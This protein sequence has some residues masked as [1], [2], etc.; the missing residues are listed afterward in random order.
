MLNNIYYVYG[1]IRRDGTPYYI[2]KGKGNR[3]WDDHGYHKPPKDR[4]ILIESNLTELGALAI[5]RRLI[6]WYGRKDINTGILMNKT[7]GGDGA[8]NPNKDK[9]S[10]SR[11]SSKLAMNQAYNNLSKMIVINTGKKRPNHSDFMKSYNAANPQSGIFHTPNGDFTL[12][13]AL[14][15]YT[16]DTLYSWCMNDKIITRQSLDKQPNFP[17]S[18]LG[19]TRREVGFHYSSGPDTVPK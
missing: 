19:K 13:E 14:L 3:A 12:K 6:R 16:R 9:L 11:K 8:T 4:V 7:D 15:H 18:W 10:K 5:E 2:G 1:Y 17:K